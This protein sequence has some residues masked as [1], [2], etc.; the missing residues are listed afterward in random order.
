MPFPLLQFI[1]V[2]CTTPETDHILSDRQAIPRA[3][4]QLAIKLA[5][6]SNSFQ[7]LD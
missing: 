5:Q 7:A 3:N 1:S 2:S 6:F 4:N